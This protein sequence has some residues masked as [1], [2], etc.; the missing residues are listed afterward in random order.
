MVI[1]PR[2]PRALAQ[3]LLGVAVKGGGFATAP[4]R[5]GVDRCRQDQ[6]PSTLSRLDDRPHPRPM[7]LLNAVAERI[8]RADKIST[9]QTPTP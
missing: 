6:L 7:R 3:R 4:E 5:L 2:D 9:V 8:E 1:R